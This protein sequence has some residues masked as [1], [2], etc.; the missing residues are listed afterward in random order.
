MAEDVLNKGK[1]FR[2]YGV[3]LRGSP[4]ENPYL[5]LVDIHEDRIRVHEHLRVALQGEREGVSKAIS[6]CKLGWNERMSGEFEVDCLPR[7]R[8]QSMSRS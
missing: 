4:N 5:E 3:D 2:V 7:H 8:R 1:D 6:G